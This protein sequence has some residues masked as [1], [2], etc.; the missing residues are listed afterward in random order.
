MTKTIERQSPKGLI[1]LVVQKVGSHVIP[2][3]LG[4]THGTF[5]Y[6]DLETSQRIRDF[7][8]GWVLADPRVHLHH[9]EGLV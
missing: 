5:I 3:F 7:L 4:V 2:L 9:A 1:T 8:S 6:I